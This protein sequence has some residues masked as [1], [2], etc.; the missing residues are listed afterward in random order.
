MR[1]EI[2]GLGTRTTVIRSIFCSYLGNASIEL[3]ELVVSTHGK[4]LTF[5]NKMDNLLTASQAIQVAVQ[6][7]KQQSRACAQL[8]FRGHR[9]VGTC[10]TLVHM[11]RHGSN[12]Q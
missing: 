8:H 9:D 3:S 4:K 6:K 2:A 5:E 11:I 7:M 1:R 12:E 10:E